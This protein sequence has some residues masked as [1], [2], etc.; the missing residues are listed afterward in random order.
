MASMP[1]ERNLALASID[2]VRPW[3]SAQLE[4][5]ETLVMQ[6]MAISFYSERVRRIGKQLCHFLFMMYLTQDGFMSQT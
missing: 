6:K 3:E 4:A 1:I 2:N 5:M